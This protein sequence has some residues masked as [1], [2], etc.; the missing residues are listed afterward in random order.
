M[1]PPMTMTGPERAVLFLLSL[2]EAI[3]APIVR[4][5]D[6]SALRQL[7][8]VAATMHAVPSGALD[9]TMKDFV[10]RSSRAVA[11]PRGGLPYLRRLS[12][13]ALGEERA[14]LLF[15]DGVASPFHRLEVAPPDAVAVLLAEEPP[16]LAGAVLARM[17]PDAAALVLRA[18][19]A[20]RQSAVVA[21]VSRMTEIQANILEEI[22]SAVAKELPDSE[23]STSVSVDGIAKAAEILNA[24]GQSSARS[25][26]SVIESDDV[27]LA[28][29]IKQ[30]MFTFEDLVRVD[31]R[32]M[33]E[34]LREVATDRLT[35]ALKNVSDELR[36]AVFSGLSSRAADLIR[37][38]LEVL[39]NPKKSEIEAARIEIVQAALRLE[40]EGRIDLGRNDG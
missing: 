22:A 37:D 11:V 10:E 3:A 39:G 21:H 9:E 24:S 35:M 27:A 26:L 12:A 28:N 32:A 29:Q 18:M 30:A 2:D 23:V 4:E 31:A 8:S 20:D 17:A 14:S 34:L 5:L 33:R 25:I 1:A 40:G 13:G 7:R 16:Q 38:D 19:P 6:E 36:N 15:E